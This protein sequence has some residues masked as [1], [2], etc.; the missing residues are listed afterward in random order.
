MKRAP[1]I[2]ID[3]SDID[4]PSGGR[5][6]VLELLR[7]LFALEADWR[8]I[9]LVS[10]READFMFPGVRQV[11]VPFRKRIL[12]RLWIQLA[13]AYYVWVKRVGLVHFA[14]T[15]GG[16]AWPARNVLTVFD[17]T[18]V[19][20][21]ELH[22]P[23]AVWLWR[24]VHPFLMRQADRIIAISQNVAD[25]LMREFRLPA[26][27]IEVVYCAPKEVFQQRV[28]QPAVDV[29]R[30]KYG[31]P[32]RYILYVGLI[33]K[34]KNLG[35]LVRAL[36]VL[37]ERQA[38]DLSLVMA[39]RRYRQSEDVDVFEQVR[40]LGL[41]AE[42]QYI[43]PVEDAD[44]PGLYGGAQVLVYPSL[45]EGFGIPCLEAM[46][47][48]VPVVAAKS[49]AIPEVVGDAALLVDDPTDV[50]QLADAIHR[51]CTDQSLRQELLARASIR[52]RQFSWSKSAEQVLALYRHLLRV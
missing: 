47:C 25:D 36:S 34:K 40:A 32:E 1:T 49:G 51:A 12:E 13:V 35:T 42:V 15:M 44:L 16:I 6:A 30:H 24:Y 22:S 28:E 20:Y 48:R 4:K 39:G 8:Y 52:V 43:G 31:L 11:I 18:A 14:R 17:I 21:P 37:H 10:Q 26:D 50:H 46:A 29:V 27:R 5:T 33:A 3:A 19:H 9:V 7:A 38:T 23:L 41:E 45:H 2:L